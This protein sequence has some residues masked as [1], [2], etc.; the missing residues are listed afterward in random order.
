[1]KNDQNNL[2]PDGFVGAHRILVGVAAVATVWLLIECAVLLPGLI[3]RYGW[4]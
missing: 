2:S 4:H 1:M 3:T